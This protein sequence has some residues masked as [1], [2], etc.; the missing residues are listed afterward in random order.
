MRLRP[1]ETR[2]KKSVPNGGVSNYKTF[3]DIVGPR[4]GTAGIYFNRE[5]IIVKPQFVASITTRDLME[6]FI[7]IVAP[8]RFVTGVANKRF[9][10][11][12]IQ[13]KCRPRAADHVFFHHHSPKIVG[14]TFECHLLDPRSLLHPR[15][16]TVF[17]IV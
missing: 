2:Q 3:R 11:F 13:A 15:A 14:S 12:C 6:Q 17:Y 9:D 1:R 4:W 8:A 10:L 7:P 16:L 5:L